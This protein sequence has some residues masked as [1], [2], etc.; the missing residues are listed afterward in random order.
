VNKIGSAIFSP[1][2]KFRYT[3][4]RILSE[5]ELSILFILLNPSK[6]DEY[7]NDN[8]VAKCMKYGSMWGYGRFTVCNIFALRSTDPRGLQQSLNEGVD[9]IGEENDKAILSAANLADL[10]VCGWGM[11]GLLNNRGKNVARSLLPF[12][13]KLH[14]LNLCKDGT[15][16]HPL[17]LKNNLRPQQWTQIGTYL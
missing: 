9:P 15:P 8:T 13:D 11:H 17:Y 4:N 12:K 5:S 7:I 3:L 10:I 6:A 2:L 16:G 14:Y 1:C